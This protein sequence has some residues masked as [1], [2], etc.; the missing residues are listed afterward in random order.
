[1]LA[2]FLIWMTRCRAS[3]SRSFTCINSFADTYHAWREKGGAYE[4]V[5]GFAKSATD[6]EIAE[7]GFVLTP[8]RFVG[9]AERAPDAEAFEVKMKR[10]TAELAEQMRQGA[11]LDEAIRINMAKVGHGW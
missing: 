3:W 10:L 7:Q 4:D 2:D 11:I 5:A 1:M 8:G 6:A 9:N